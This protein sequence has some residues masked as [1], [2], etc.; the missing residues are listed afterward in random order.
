MEAIARLT[1]KNLENPE[2]SILIGAA[3]GDVLSRAVWLSGRVSPIPLCGGL[4]LCG[5]CRA[6]F[7]SAPPPLPADIKFFKAE[8]L[9]EGWRLTCRRR[10]EK[11]ETIYLPPVSFRRPSADI[12][13]GARGSCALGI[14]LG[15]TNIEW[16]AVANKTAVASGKTLNPQAGAGSDCVSRLDVASIPCSVLADLALAEIGSI[17]SALEK[18]GAFPAML[19][20]AANTV[21][22]E[23]LLRKDV[24]GLRAAPYT[25]AYQGGEIINLEL[26][27]GV[28]RTVIPPLIAP[29]VG[30]DAACAALSCAAAAYPRPMLIADLGT[31]AEFLLL[32]ENDEL[33]A[34]S[35]P[36]GPAFEGVGPSGGAMAGP[37]VVVS[38]SISPAG[39][40]ET[41]YAPGATAAIG[42]TGYLSLLAILSRIGAMD[43][44]GRFV[45]SSPLA[46]NMAKYIF[47]END[48]S[49]A[50]LPRDLELWPED[51]EL[52]LKAKAAFSLA[53]KKLLSFARLSPSDI[54]SFCLAGALG[55]AANIADLI[56][57]GF[58]P[59]SFEDRTIV[60]GNAALDGAALLAMEPG[61]LDYLARIRAG[62]RVLPLAEDKDFLNAYLSEMRWLY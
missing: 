49:R 7:P 42:A 19:C 47:P 1:L 33:F 57:L 35:V 9:E 52:L 55:G 26:L 32:K 38:Y 23:I 53:I 4:A 22:T 41:L 3:K 60:V 17:V 34:T 58:A 40:K 24:S 10:V 39:L 14:D 28:Y 37:G 29:F 51:V 36:M 11:D 5:N 45:A 43:D 13:V 44:S 20:V 46:R 48:F 62:A 2:E 25:L 18:K 59:A 8:E 61:R 21:M 6:L 50:R 27:D 12:A 56:E 15:T 30:G 54:N 31:N 16:R